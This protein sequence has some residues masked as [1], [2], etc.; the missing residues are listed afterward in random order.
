[1]QNIEFKKSKDFTVGVE[2]ELQIIDPNSRDLVSKCSDILKE[3]GKNANIK[4]EFYESCIEINSDICNSISDLEKNLLRHVHILYEAARKLGL[5]ITMAGTHP[6]ANWSKQLV[7]PNKRY[8][9]LENRIRMP[10]QRMLTFGIHVHVGLSSGPEAV[11]VNNGLMNYLPHLLALSCSSPYWVKRDSGMESYRVKIIETLPTTGL[12]YKLESWDEFCELFGIL[13]KAGTMESFRE[14]WW[15]TRPHP[16]FGTVEVRICD[17]MPLFQDVISIAALV[18]SLIA[19]FAFKFRANEK[20]ETLS[21]VLIRQNKWRAARY[22]LDGSFIIN[23]NGDVSPIKDEIEK[24]VKLAEPIS[25][26]LE[27][28]DQLKEIKNLLNRDTN[29]KRQRKIFEETKGTWNS[30]IDDLINEFEDS[31]QLKTVET[32]HDKS[33]L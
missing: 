27:S 23:R 28:H 9:N 14:I 1:M 15:D 12:P 3:L 18:Q 10:V 20:I 13:K 11:A 29:S 33:L 30:I 26:Q 2:L 25:K 7:S 31:W 17:A 32:C 6:T 16:D 8:L 21:T 5:K 4:H 19:H 24:L 22:G